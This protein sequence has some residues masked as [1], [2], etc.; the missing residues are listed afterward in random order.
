[1]ARSLQAWQRALGAA[2]AGG[3]MVAEGPLAGSIVPGAPG[4]SLLNAVAAPHRA[5]LDDATLDHVRACYE[6]AGVEAW[7]VWV[8]EDDGAAAAA[9]ARGGLVIDSR[10]AA[11]ALDLAGEPAGSP[12]GATEVE[13]AADIAAMAGPLSA[14]YG[15]PAALLTGALPGLLDHVEGWVGRRDG[16]A[17]AAAVIVRCDDDA[18]VFMVGTAPEHRGHGVATAVLD[19]ALRAARAAGCTTSTLQASAMGRPVYARMGY[20]ELGRYLLWERRAGAPPANAAAPQHGVTS[21]APA[22]APRRA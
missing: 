3:S 16:A 8:H 11:M 22:P 19:A 1:M 2:A 4:M 21:P 15:F 18:G 20:A 17:A 5:V 6:H 10:P 7:G 9:L 13:R 14:A 12:A